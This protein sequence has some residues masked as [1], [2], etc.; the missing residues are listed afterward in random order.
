VEILKWKGDDEYIVC[1][2][3][4]ILAHVIYW[5]WIIFSNW[6]LTLGDLTVELLTVPA[7][8]IFGV[9]VVIQLVLHAFLAEKEDWFLSG[10]LI[11][12]ITFSVW[13]SVVYPGALITAIPI[14]DIFVIAL[15]SGGIGGA[16]A[17]TYSYIVMVFVKG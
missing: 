3:A 17:M 15:L 14:M 11:I 5:I 9:F 6:G 7:V 2:A 4:S 12:A 1:A 10:G 13:T 8:W 16:V